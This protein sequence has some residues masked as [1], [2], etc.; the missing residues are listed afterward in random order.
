M[1]RFWII[2]A[3]ALVVAALPLL[4]RLRDRRLARRVGYV[5][6]PAV[7]AFTHRL[8]VPCRTQQAPALDRLRALMPSVRIEVVDVE[9]EPEIAR[10]Y[11]IFTVPSTVVIGASGRALAFNHGLAGEHRLARQLADDPRSETSRRSRRSR[12]WETCR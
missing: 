11:G 2:L 9:R 4:L 8:C 7:L 1:D 6:G 3:I 10:R 12:G 5:E